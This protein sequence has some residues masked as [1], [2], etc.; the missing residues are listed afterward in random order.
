MFFFTSKDP[1]CYTAR[2]LVYSLRCC[3]V[4]ACSRVW[5]VSGPKLCDGELTRTVP[6]RGR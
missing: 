5:E 4:F 1:V 6:C 2:L 3:G